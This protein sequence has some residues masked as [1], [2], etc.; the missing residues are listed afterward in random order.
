MRAGLAKKPGTNLNFIRES[1]DMNPLLTI[2]IIFSLSLVGAIVLFKCLK[3]SA[4]IQ[5]ASYQAG[6]A[7]A[8][9]ILIY[10]ML[11]YSYSEI[12]AVSGPQ[13]WTVEGQ[14]Q[15]ENAEFD[16]QDLTILVKPPENHLYHSGAFVIEKVPIKYPFGTRKPSLIVTKTGYKPTE[17]I[18]DNS[19]PNII[20]N[21]K[22]KNIKIKPP[23]ALKK[24][25][26]YTEAAAYTPILEEETL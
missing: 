5:K 26:R 20:C 10:S 11:Y 25:I 17:I 13:R 9:F 21:Q 24:Q 19:Q 14:I 7:V 12:N 16:S 22:T 3:S 15:L 1:N 6:G 23:I 4:M 18:L 2:G 8:G